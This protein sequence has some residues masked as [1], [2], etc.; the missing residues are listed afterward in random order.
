MMIAA[1]P[2]SGAAPGVER[3]PFA[4][5]LRRRVGALRIRPI[6]FGIRLGRRAVEDEVAAV[7]DERS[8][9]G[10]R[11]PRERAHAERVRRQRIDG[12][13]FG[14]VHVRERRAV[15]DD[16]RPDAR[17]RRRDRRLVGDVEIGARKGDHLMIRPA[18]VRDRGAQLAARTGDDNPH[19]AA[20]EAPSSPNDR[21]RSS[22]STPSQRATT[23]VAMQLPMTFTAVRPMSMIWSMPS[24][25]A[26]PSSGRP[27]CVSVAA[28][29]TSAAR[30][31]PATPLLVSISVSIITSC[32]PI[33]IWT[34]A[35]CATN[36]LASDR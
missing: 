7:V 5:E 15:D 24:R 35:S 25:I 16:V 14:G 4:Q 20:R 11:G 8:A 36:T 29:T 31:T 6:G 9:V 23:A 26:A 2:F 32:W 12:T 28:R 22:S 10:L 27:N 33:V 1:L 21:I 17:D 18:L 19:Q 34:P 13:I 30:G 3:K